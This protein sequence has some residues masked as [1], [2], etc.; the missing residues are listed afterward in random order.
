MAVRRRRRKKKPTSKTKAFFKEAA[1]AGLKQSVSFVQGGAMAVV[2][3]EAGETAAGV[4]RGVTVAAGIAGQALLD[5]EEHPTKYDLAG[6]LASGAMYGQGHKTVDKRWAALKKSRA[7]KQKKEMISQLK[8]D[9]ESELE[10]VS[11]R[12]G[13]T[14]SAPPE[15]VPVPKKTNKRPEKEG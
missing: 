2:E 7:E 14:V 1:K 5:R 4:V 6:N 15:E 13:V 8:A 12:N 11:K 3:H 9:M 10:E